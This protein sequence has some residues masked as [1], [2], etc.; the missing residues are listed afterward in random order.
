ME[1]RVKGTKYDVR[2]NR[3][4]RRDYCNNYQYHCYNNQYPTNHKET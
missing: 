1:N 2:N 3:W 4:Y